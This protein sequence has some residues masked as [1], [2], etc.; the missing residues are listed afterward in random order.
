M[1][2]SPLGWLASRHHVKRKPVAIGEIDRPLSSEGSGLL[3]VG[4]YRPLCVNPSNDIG[5]PPGDP[6]GTK[7]HWRWEGSLPDAAP[8]RGSGQGDEVEHLTAPDEPGG[9]VCSCARRTSL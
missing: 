7:R 1:N 9:G 5:L 8:N 4:A 3:L 6:S 2:V